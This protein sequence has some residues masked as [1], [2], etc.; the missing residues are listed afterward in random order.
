MTKISFILFLSCLFNVP[1]FQ[2]GLKNLISYEI[3][4]KNIIFNSL[5]QVRVNCTNCNWSTTLKIAIGQQ[6]LKL[7]LVNN[8]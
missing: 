6:H 7:Q 4:E 3:K 5:K 2:K 1:N 8:T